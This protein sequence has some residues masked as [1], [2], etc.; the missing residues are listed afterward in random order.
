MHYVIKKSA[1]LTAPVSASAV[2]RNKKVVFFSLK[3]PPGPGI[4]GGMDA[5]LKV[6]AHYVAHSLL[7]KAEQ[8]FF[9]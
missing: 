9:I 7:H 4:S 8:Y 5:K 3:D 6:R 1:V 2:K